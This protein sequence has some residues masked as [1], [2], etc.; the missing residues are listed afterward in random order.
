M[1]IQDWSK[2][3]VDATQ[4]FD[5]AIADLIGS[6][7]NGIPRC[8]IEQFAADWIVALLTQWQKDNL[9]RIWSYR[10]EAQEVVGFERAYEEHLDKQ[11]R[12]KGHKE[13]SG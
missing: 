3:G 1:D 12:S 7:P 5:K 9:V 13:C 10:G 8:D 2:Y 4:D 6:R 11:K